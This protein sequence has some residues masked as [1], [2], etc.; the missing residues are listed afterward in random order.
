MIRVRVFTVAEQAK[1]FDA[2]I[3]QDKYLSTH[4]G[5]YAERNAVFLP[6]VKRIDLS[7]SQ[8]V[9]HSIKGMRH[10]GQ[11]RLDITNFGNL[12]NHNWGAGQRLVQNQILTNAGADA[13]GRAT[14]RMAVVNNALP[15]KSLQTTTFAA[16]VYTL[17]LS[18]RYNF[19]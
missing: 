9:F 15:T 18:F 4:R 3:Q 14:Y 12:L 8:D 10:S 2:Y 1:A 19:N 17:M 7:V 5:E 13:Q 6:L 16:D 11:I